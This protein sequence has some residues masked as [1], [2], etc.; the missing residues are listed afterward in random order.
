MC[1]VLFALILFCNKSDILNYAGHKGLYGSECSFILELIKYVVQEQRGNV[2]TAQ[3]ISVYIY[4]YILM[5]VHM[6]V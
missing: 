3:L 6:Y 2:S 5:C 1:F 4:I